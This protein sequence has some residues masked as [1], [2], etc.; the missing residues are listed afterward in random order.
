MKK[1]YILSALMLSTMGAMAQD[2]YLNDRMTNNANG[3]YGTA[4]YVGMGGAMGALGADISTMSWNPAGIGLMRRSDLNMT[5]GAGWDQTGTDNVKKAHGTFDQLGGVFSLPFADSGLRNIN[6]GFNYQKKLDFN[7]SFTV[8][9]GLNGLSQLDQ[10]CAVLNRWGSHDAGGERYPSLAALAGNFYSEKDKYSFL[11]YDETSQRYSNAFRGEG[12]AYWQHTWGGLNTYDFNV[13]GNVNDR[14]FWGLTFSFDQ[15]RYRMSN[16]YYEESYRPHTEPNVEYGDY[17]VYNDQAVNGYGLNAKLG[18]IVRPIEDSPFRFA[19]VLETPTKYSLRTNTSFQIEDHVNNYHTDLDITD[20][21]YGSPFRYALASPMK[22]RMGIGSTVGNYLAFDVDYEFANT[23]NTR[24]G[25]FRDNYREDEA[26]L[27]QSDAD[28][29]MNE[30]TKQNFK[31][32]HTV[33]AGIEAK[34]TDKFSVR[35]G[36]NFISSAQ[37]DEPHFSQ[38]IASDALNNATSTCF[39][40]MKPT[41]MVTLGMGY[42]WKYVYIDAAYK[43]MSQKADF[44]PFEDDDA[45]HCTQN[46]P[47]KDRD[48]VAGTQPASLSL[49]RHQITATL[50]VRF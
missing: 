10:L 1:L 44:Y 4:R 34:P 14:F 33:R 15:L 30:L 18:L 46:M 37:K 6:F 45:M 28:A 12:F 38:L 23:R 26:M 31:N 25:Y 48:L 19:M 17:S 32:T 16:E 20:L 9:G 8:E 27:F 41:Y 7:N 3:L 24:M 39:M 43:C 35:A 5:F 13:S 22:L 36:F 2:S 40:H 49:V 50:G 21:Y 42:R 11:Q 47:F 29:E